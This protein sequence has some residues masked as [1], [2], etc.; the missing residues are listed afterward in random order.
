M[1]DVSFERIERDCKQCWDKPE[2][3]AD[4]DEDKLP[5]PDRRSKDLL[6]VNHGGGVRAAVNE[7]E[8]YFGREVR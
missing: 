5:D 2:T 4:G 3:H 6:A 1:H 8:E 7:A